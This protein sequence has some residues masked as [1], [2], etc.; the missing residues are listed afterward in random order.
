MVSEGHARSQV[1]PSQRKLSSE[2][3]IKSQAVVIRWQRMGSGGKVSFEEEETADDKTQ[4]PVKTQGCHD[5]TRSSAGAQGSMCG[6]EG[7][8]EQ[9]IR[10]KRNA[11]EALLCGHGERM[12]D[13][14]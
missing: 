4:R 11:A 3:G 14:Q 8:G 7:A 13:F 5:V 6:E 2:L 9:R 1:P 12:Q 10:L